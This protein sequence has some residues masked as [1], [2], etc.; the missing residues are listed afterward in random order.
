MKFN[1]LFVYGIYSISLFIDFVIE[2]DIYFFF[3]FFSDF[4]EW[5]LRTR[6]GSPRF[7]KTYELFVFL[8]SFS[9][10]SPG[11]YGV[12]VGPRSRLTLFNLAFGAV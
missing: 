4:N 9:P 5:P 8:I 12:F 1:T 3:N 7:L 2:I 10:S 6:G 11:N